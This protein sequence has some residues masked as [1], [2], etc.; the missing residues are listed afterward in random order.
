MSTYIKNTKQFEEE[1]RCCR[2]LKIERHRCGITYTHHVFVG[3][4]DK[5]EGCDLYHYAPANKPFLKAKFPA[6]I[7]KVRLTF[8]DHDTCQETLDI[9]DF[10]KDNVCIAERDDYPMDQKAEE[11]CIRKA[12]LRLGEEMYSVINNNCDSFVNWIFSNDNTSSQSENCDV[13]NKLVGNALDGMGSSGIL[14]PVGHLVNGIFQQSKKSKQETS[15]TNLQNSDFETENSL[16]EI[17]NETKVKRL[18]KEYET[19]MEQRHSGIFVKNVE[20]A[21]SQ[22]SERK[23]KNPKIQ[24]RKD[25][26][27]KTNDVH[28]E[29]EIDNTKPM[30]C[31]TTKNRM[32]KYT[33]DSNSHEQGRK[34]RG[35]QQQQQQ[36]QDKFNGEEEDTRYTNVKRKRNAKKN[37]KKRNNSL[38]QR[39]ERLEKERKYVKEEQLRENSKNAQHQESSKCRDTEQAQRL[40]NAKVHKLE[41]EN[42]RAREL[43]DK[44]EAKTVQ[45][46]KLKDQSYKS[47]QQ[48]TSNKTETKPSDKF[49]KKNEFV[50]KQTS[51]SQSYEAN[52]FNLWTD[53][54]VLTVGRGLVGAS[55]MCSKKVI[56]AIENSDALK[57]ILEQQFKKSAKKQISKCVCQKAKDEGIKKVSQTVSKAGVCFSVAVEAVSLT[58]N[59]V[60]IAS[61]GHMTSEQKNRSISREVV[62][63]ASGF[64]GTFIG[65]ALIPIPVVGSLV[66]GVVGNAIGGMLGGGIFS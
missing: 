9:F 60:N 27:N 42:A 55:S 63:S 3:K 37:R 18:A 61:D 48:Q 40:E 32:R 31:D 1:I 47:H 22:D 45:S 51:G 49:Q 20:K 16:S 14:R 58:V 65:Q 35:I 10:D 12:E 13:I 4:V 62:T 36:Q 50:K 64:A 8:E 17:T 19:K 46:E 43:K 57:T 26:I 59:I 25:K 44:I 21:Y 34:A 2:E 30:N 15:K 66:G 54:S 6:K 5:G 28:F 29:K 41:A 38:S 24:T 52:H 33:K 56:N 53:E 11:K 39:L 23:N 7:K